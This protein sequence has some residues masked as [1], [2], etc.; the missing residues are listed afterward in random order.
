MLQILRARNQDTKRKVAVGDVVKH[1]DEYFVIIKILKI[2]P[3]ANQAT[4][5]YDLVG[6]KAS[7]ES[8]DLGGKTTHTFTK[9]HYTQHGKDP[10]YKIGK[11]IEIKTTDF[12]VYG[13]ISSIKQVTFVKKGVDVTYEVELIQEWTESQ[14]ATA[15]KNYKRSLLK[16]C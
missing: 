13:T 12:V 10:V 2:A 6:Q 16:V 15:V 11:L 1:H 14:I 8:L 7:K 5:D 4:Y 3:H 9:T